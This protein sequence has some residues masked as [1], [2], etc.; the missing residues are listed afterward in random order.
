MRQRK[1]LL[2]MAAKLAWHQQHQQAVLAAQRSQ[3]TH[4]PRQWSV[5]LAVLVVQVAWALALVVQLASTLSFWVLV[6]AAAVA[7]APRVLMAGKL[8]IGQVLA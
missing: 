3:P 4:G 2:P 1:R 6:A 5:A 7:M 8:V